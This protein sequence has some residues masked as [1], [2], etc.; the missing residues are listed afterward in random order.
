MLIYGE[1]AAESPATEKKIEEKTLWN[2]LFA[3]VFKNFSLPTN[4]NELFDIRNDVMHFHFI[5]YEQYKRSL[6]LLKEINKELDA[7]LEKGIVLENNDDNA[8]LVSN[9]YQYTFKAISAMAETIRAINEQLSLI[10]MSSIVPIVGALNALKQDLTFPISEITKGL[11]ST[12]ST[13]YESV[14]ENNLLSEIDEFEE[15]E[16]SEYEESETTEETEDKSAL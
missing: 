6:R 11:Y 4:Q 5:S 16:K 10:S 8:V 14:D 9:N 1:Y 13:F 3:P 12:L 15:T 7:Q 2:E